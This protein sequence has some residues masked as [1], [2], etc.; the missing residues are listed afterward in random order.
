MSRVF[1]P[2]R[3]SELWFEE[4]DKSVN[5]FADKRLR[6]A[7]YKLNEIGS[8]IWKLCDGERRN[9]EIADLVFDSLEDKRTGAQ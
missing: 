9:E 5:L 6:L 8:F 3:I 1:Y 4:D 7:R 2:I